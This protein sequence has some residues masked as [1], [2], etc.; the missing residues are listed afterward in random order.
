MNGTIECDVEDEAVEAGVRDQQV[1]ASAEHEDGEVVLAGEGN[2][3]EEFG[4]RVDFDE[5]AR[6]ASD[7]E[8][9]EGSEQDVLVDRE[10]GG[11]HGFEGT[12]KDRGSRGGL[13]EAAEQAWV[14][15]CEYRK[16]HPEGAA[17]SRDWLQ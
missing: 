4:F 6:W 2:G 13:L 10:R 7:A 11:W 12:T 14:M 15:R 17:A 1:A 8:S 9:G 16:V 3:F 5:V